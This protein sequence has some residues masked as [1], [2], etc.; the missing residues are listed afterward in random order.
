MKKWTNEEIEYLK[1]HYA[2]ME[3][4]DLSAYF[5]RSENAVRAKCFDL[6]LVKKDKWN[7]YDIEFLKENYQTMST[8]DT[9]V[10]LQRTTSAVKI[11]A[12][13]LGLSKYPYTCDYNYFD[14][15]DSEEKAYWL[16]FIFADGYISVNENNNSGC[17]GIDLCLSDI[18]HLKKFNKSINGNYQITQRERQCSLSDSKDVF[19]CCSLRIFS[20]DMVNSLRQYGITNHKSYDAVFPTI[21][22][23]FIRHFIRGYFDGDGC[24]YM[25]KRHDCSYL[26]C[27]F[28]SCSKVF[29]EQLRSVLY[30]Q[31]INSH[32]WCETKN[33]KTPL[34]ILATSGKQNS[35][36]LLCF[37][38]ESSS[39]YLD[40]KFRYY[41]NN[42]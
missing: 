30:D 33:R 1:T 34:Y 10:A 5:E 24:V 9:A 40:R 37:M 21:N 26:Q 41:E 3:Y 35:L 7:N 20:I 23:D 18:G 11:K 28:Y 8:S 22:K 36:D 38:Y 2:D 6:N 27:T 32:I 17:V 19:G 16:G 4:S 14:N 25:K 13:K 39:I 31:D 29:L 15:I 12:R 42:K